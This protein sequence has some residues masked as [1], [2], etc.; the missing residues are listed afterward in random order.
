MGKRF[1][2]GKNF[3]YPS[4]FDAL[5]WQTG[6]STRRV[7]G[8]LGR[9][10]R[11]VHDWREGRRPVL[12]WA[13]E[14]V[15][16]IAWD[17]LDVWGVDR[18]FSV[19]LVAVDL[20]PWFMETEAANEAPRV[21]AKRAPG[22]LG[23][24]WGSVSRPGSPPLVTRGETPIWRQIDASLIPCN[25]EA[26][27]PPFDSPPVSR[28][29]PTAMRL[30]WES[31][32]ML[33]WRWPFGTTWLPA[34]THPPWPRSRWRF[35]QREE[36]PRGG[37]KARRWHRVESLSMNGSAGGRPRRRLNGEG[38]FCKPTAAAGRCGIPT[39]M[40]PEAWAR[41][42][43]VAPSAGARVCEELLPW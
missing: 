27:L 33:S 14:L 13:F 18:H 9:T 42:G 41:S 2:S 16:F 8:W 39:S 29:K 35:L 30:S 12:R 23:S 24:A 28:Q 22:G 21:G 6:T 32:S 38:F 7:A 31:R 19:H 20:R 17:R 10:G 36:A 37:P 40:R 5:L 25:A 34:A 11:T 1:R 26:W 4:E 43:Q 3:V 15:K